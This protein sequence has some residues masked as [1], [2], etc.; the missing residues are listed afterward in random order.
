MLSV[1]MDTKG[2][3][4]HENMEWSGM[5]FALPRCGCDNKWG[6]LWKSKQIILRFSRWDGIG[7][8]GIKLG[9]F[10]QCELMKK[11]L[12]CEKN[13]SAKILT[14]NLEVYNIVLFPVYRCDINLLCK[15]ADLYAATSRQEDLTVNVIE[16]MARC[17][18]VG[19]SDIHRQIQWL[20]VGTDSFIIWM[21]T[22]ILLKRFWNFTKISN[23]ESKL[24]RVV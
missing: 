13:T 21:M 23:L 11:N 9:K 8:I 4:A 3:W 10:C 2:T 19:S 24:E 1:N 7:G 17:L 5:F 14:V 22:L 12:S 16:T 18:S 15:I 20:Q 6:R